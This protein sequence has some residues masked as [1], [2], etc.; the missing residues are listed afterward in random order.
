MSDVKI[1]AKVIEDEAREQIELLAQQKSF[2]GQKIRIMPDVHAGKGC[3]IGFIFENFQKL[4]PLYVRVRIDNI[5]SY[6][7]DSETYALR[8][9]KFLQNTKIGKLYGDWND[10]GRLL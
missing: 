7:Q 3:V 9:D 8:L 10:G 4:P 1:F 2:C 6:P 5:Q